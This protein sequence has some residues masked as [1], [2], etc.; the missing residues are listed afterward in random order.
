MNQQNLMQQYFDH[1]QQQQSNMNGF[2]GVAFSNSQQIPSSFNGPTPPV[3]NPYAVNSNYRQQNGQRFNDNEPFE[4]QNPSNPHPTQNF[5]GYMDPR[6]AGFDPRNRP[7]FDPNG[8]P[9]NVPE[10]YA[11]PGFPG[12]KIRMNEMPAMFNNPAVVAAMQR[13]RLG[14]YGPSPG[15]ENEFM[16]QGNNFGGFNPQALQF[17]QQQQRYEA[18]QRQ[19]QQQLVVQQQQQQSLP[20]SSQIQGVSGAM[21]FRESA[22]TTP[23]SNSNENSNDSKA[24]HISADTPEGFSPQVDNQL[25]TTAVSNQNEISQ[26]SNNNSMTTTN[27]TKFSSSDTPNKT[28]VT[29]QQK[30]AAMLAA[31]AVRAA[32]AA[33]SRGRAGFPSPGGAGSAP[34]FGSQNYSSPNEQTSSPFSHG[35]QSPDYNNVMSPNKDMKSLQSPLNQQRSGTPRSYSSLPPYSPSMSNSDSNHA[36]SN[37]GSNI[38]LNKLS[39]QLKLD[40]SNLPMQVKEQANNGN[41][42][43]QLSHNNIMKSNSVEEHLNDRS[44]KLSA[45]PTPMSMMS[46]SSPAPSLQDDLDALDGLSPSWPQTPMSPDAQKALKARASP[47]HYEQLSKVYD[48]IDNDEKRNFMDR[49]LAFM[50]V[51]GTPV[52]KIPIIG[53]KPL[54]LYKLFRAVCERGG[55]QEIM[56]KRRF[57]EVLAILN[58]STGNGVL[59]YMVKD[60]YMKYLHAYELKAKDILLKQW[61]TTLKN[62]KKSEVPT[63][64][65]NDTFSSAINV[66]QELLN[67]KQEIQ[68]HTPPTSSIATSSSSVTAA[69][70]SSYQ[71]S[72]STN[73]SS[74]SSADAQY[75]P[76]LSYPSPMLPTQPVS[77]YGQPGVPPGYPNGPEIPQGYS[78]YGGYQNPMFSRSHINNYNS[79]RPGLPTDTAAPGWGRG[80]PPRQGPPEL[81][82]EGLQRLPWNQQAPRHAMS[83][84]NSPTFPGANNIN[85]SQTPNSR[86]QLNQLSAQQLEQMKQEQQLK[87]QQYQKQQSRFQHPDQVNKQGPFKMSRPV[88]PDIKP[89]SIPTQ[90]G[91]R[92]LAFT[93]DTVEGTRPLTVKRRKLTSKDLGPVE[94]WR[95]MMSLKSGLVSEC[96]WAINTLNILLSDNTTIT[97][98]HLNQLPGL[99]DTLMDHYRRSISDLFSSFKDLE[100]PIYPQIDKDGIGEQSYKTVDHKISDLWIGVCKNSKKSFSSNVATFA[101]TANSNETIDGGKK[102][103]ERGGADN[104]SHIQ[105]CFPAEEIAVKKFPQG[106]IYTTKVDL[107]KQRKLEILKEKDSSKSLLKNSQLNE[108]TPNVNETNVSE[109]NSICLG[110][111][112]DL[113]S[114]IDSESK[115]ESDDPK[116][117]AIVKKVLT[118]LEFSIPCDKKYLEDSKEFISYLNRRLHR[119][120]RGNFKSEQCVIKQNSPFACVTEKEESLYNRCVALS[121]IFR[122]LS[123]IQGNDTELANHVGLLLIAGYSLLYKHEHMWT[124]HSQFKLGLDERTVVNNAFADGMD[125]LFRTSLTSIREN[126]LVMLSNIGGHINMTKVSKDISQPLINGLLHWL[127][128]RSSDALDPM[129]TAPGT[130]AL[131]AQRLA[132]ETLAKMTINTANIDLIVA[133]SN[134]NQLEEIGDILIKQVS[135]KHPVPT[136]E[137]AIILLDNLCQSQDFSQIL[138]QRKCAV[139]NL[140][141]FVY[142]AEK[143]TSNYLSSGGRVQPGLNA[144]DICGTSISLLRRSVNIILSLSKTPSNKRYLVPFTDDILSLSTS[145]MIDTSVLALLASVLFELTV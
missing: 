140:V 76:R 139:S 25:N 99:L 131:S 96:A 40:E 94:A 106:L 5:P 33:T 31:A 97:Y 125:E 3:S 39:P 115:V 8:V 56:H 57:T 32:A 75:N 118:N 18:F 63:I 4:M 112:D 48:L 87:L 45:P 78:G 17:M 130:Y 85:R 91:K 64:S 103:W 119:E 123:F 126:M 144:E 128:C 16:S 47:R 77:A 28:K 117:N 136:R 98:F 23:K 66:K 38:N 26:R 132:M 35:M 101:V 95:I 100:I 29:E 41:S 141:K 65:L 70:N 82:P 14:L 61:K 73:N 134:N 42:V 84:F 89:S 111:L 24:K 93:P 19:V 15:R 20:V 113:L 90:P 60:Q 54:D 30:N 81:F 86:E 52:T 74:S 80:Y 36:M 116:T 120:N 50:S 107:E 124:D 27:N 62:E 59:A 10:G 1:Q 71:K 34:S 6:L 135:K 79:V 122:S 127:S 37:K 133:A 9:P 142:E 105:P 109:S 21:E 145:Q 44:N 12:G 46:A 51:N 22:S 53:R 13:R 55:I 138:C 114:H 43:N 72:S 143:N 102:Y 104:T 92:E 110:V 129:P 108:N 2:P 7:A 121:N 49:Y 11:S 83:A 88:A 137:F 67:V 58:L 69:W 68:N